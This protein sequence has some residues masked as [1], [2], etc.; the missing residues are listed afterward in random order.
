MCLI[1]SVIVWAATAGWAPPFTF[2]TGY[3][4]PRPLT[5]RVDFE[6]LD[7][8]GESARQIQARKGA[9]WYYRNDPEPLVLLR[10]QLKESLFKILR[11]ESYDAVDKTTWREFY[12]DAQAADTGSDQRVE[13]DRLREAFQDDPDLTKF[14]QSLDKV[15]LQYRDSSLGTSSTSL[16]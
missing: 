6:Q 13:F 3:I 1:A 9:T 4:P 11:S 16:K 5:S 8:A 14:D 10:K 15:M 7:Q 12:P 2:R